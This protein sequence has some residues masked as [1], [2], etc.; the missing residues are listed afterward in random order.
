MLNPLRIS[1]IV[2][3]AERALDRVCV[4][5]SSDSGA[6][7]RGSQSK[8]GFKLT[9]AELFPRMRHRH[10]VPDLIVGT[11]LEASETY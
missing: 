2:E 3:F 11:A 10:C 8:F 1:L 4:A 9:T 5:S 7:G 6:F